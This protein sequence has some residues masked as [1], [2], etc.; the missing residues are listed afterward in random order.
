[1]FKGMSGWSRVEEKIIKC[2]EVEEL[3]EGDLG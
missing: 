3:R 1:M 2:V